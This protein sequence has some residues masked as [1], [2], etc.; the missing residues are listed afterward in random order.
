MESVSTWRSM[1]PTDI[2][3]MRAIDGE[4]ARQGAE[5]Y[6]SQLATRVQLVAADRQVTWRCVEGAIVSAIAEQRVTWAWT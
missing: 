5:E 1:L 6:L 3:L 4:S 2:V